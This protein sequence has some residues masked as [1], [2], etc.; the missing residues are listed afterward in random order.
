ML[1]YHAIPLFMPTTII[2]N[3]LVDKVHRVIWFWMFTLWRPNTF[4]VICVFFITGIFFF[5]FSAL[6]VFGDGQVW[7]IILICIFSMFI[8]LL[9]F[10]VW[11]QP[12]NNIE[13]IFKV[14]F[15]PF[16]PAASLFINIYL[17]LHMDKR[18]WIGYA[19]FMI[20]GN[21]IFIFSH[22]TSRKSWKLLLH[23]HTL[24]RYNQN[25][26]IS[27]SWWIFKILAMIFM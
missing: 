22:F 21:Y 27:T 8:A 2:G 24:I 19:G 1:K 14:P 4:K 7:A 23:F 20:I 15:V 13:L 12:Q 18:T 9:L 6:I 25:I 3:A 10:I 26:S 16:V 17:L 11:K 5:G